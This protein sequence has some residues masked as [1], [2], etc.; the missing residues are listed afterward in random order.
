MKADDGFNLIDEP[1]IVV[2]DNDVHV[3]QVSI[4]QIFERAQDF[5]AIGGEVPTQAFAI[6]RLLLAFLHRALD[7]PV[8]QDEWLQLWTAGILPMDRIRGYAD[9]VRHRFDL[10][11][12]V[13]PFYQVAD[14]RTPRDELSGLEKVVADLPNG[15][16][17]FTTRSAVSVERLD[18][19]EAARWLVHAHAFDQSGIKSG[20]VGDPA[21]KQGKGYPIG[22]GWS[23]QLGGIL[24]QGSDL[25]ETLV[26]NLIG[27]NVE[28]YVRIGT[29]DDLPP[30]E[31]DPDGPAG[32]ERPPRGAIDLYTWQT[33][34]V[35]L[36]GT[37]DGVVGVVLANGDRI[38][39]QNRHRL[40][41]HSAWRYSEPQ[42]K[43]YKAT[44]YMPFTHDPDRSMWRGLSALVPAV[45]GRRSA[46][47]TDPQPYL[48]PGVLQWISDLVAQD[49]LPENYR[50]GIRA[51]G[52][53]YAEQN[54]TFKDIIDDELPLSIL[55][56]RA[57]HPEAGHAAVGAVEDA[58]AAAKET[59][60][61]AENIARAAG[62]EPKSGVGD[63][64]RELLY[65]RLDEPYRRWVAALG[66]G[67]DIDA[68]RKQW[69]R[70][71][72]STA[73]SIAGDLVAAAPPSAWTGREVRN[74][75]INVAIAETWF[76]AALRRMNPPEQP[77]AAMTPEEATL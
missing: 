73:R 14:L 74:R 76:R 40:E 15:E 33:R 37:R 55:V 46:K 65:A 8:D 19:A 16:P 3:H 69:R 23:G 13:A 52:V 30:W 51:C 11:D 41:P 56:L 34:R 24:A 47:N 12:P 20:A 31:R 48:V 60:K 75:L 64:A 72:D 39:P 26:L 42:T 66:P 22:T 67:V 53:Q 21:V 28:T 50:P 49:Y 27:R 32:A 35:R 61:L 4:L 7:G 59:W 17:F 71:V 9:K 25:R 63:S 2:I 10:F 36:A 45:S 62:A 70:V 43:K 44:V 1:W 38:Q 54:A 58:D 6:T 77:P 29:A 68:T 5:A 57:D 18:A